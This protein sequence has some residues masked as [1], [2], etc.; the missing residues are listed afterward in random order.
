MD[1]TNPSI[2]DLVSSVQKK[3]NIDFAEA[4]AQIPHRGER[5]S[6]REDVV[7]KFLS[8]YLPKRFGVSPGFVVD[9][10]GAVSHQLDCIVYDQLSAPVF[11]ITDGQR[12]FP[13]ESVAGVVSIKSFLDANQLQSV[14]ENLQSVTKLDRY[15]SGRPEV[16]FGG[17]PSP[18]VHGAFE[19][20]P[21][22]PIFVSAFAFDSPSLKTVA[23]NLH[24]LTS[25]LDPTHRVQLVAVLNKGVITYQDGQIAG[26][27]YSPT[28]KVSFI[29]D[30][31]SS[32]GLFYTWF[33][34]NVIRK[35]PLHISLRAYLQMPA[36]MAQVV[37]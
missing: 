17:V 5:G 2:R 28:A 21:I 31:E 12:L 33:A 24:N 23:V 13:A 20:G 19:G 14:V 15:A 6:G 26:P 36:V 9:A 30:G 4:T 8:D 35:L 11:P 1:K 7:R 34:N 22:E 3:M 16:M 18:F 32:L 27:S 10:T 37:D 29:A 25:G